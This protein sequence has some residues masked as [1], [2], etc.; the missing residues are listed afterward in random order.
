M[1][2]EEGREESIKTL[3]RRENF[4]DNYWQKRD[5]IIL[6]RLHWRA[7]SFRHLVHLL[8]GQTILEIGC[9]KGLF[10]QQLYDVT[11]NENPITAVTFL[12]NSPALFEN[13]A[14]LE[15]LCLSSLTGQLKGR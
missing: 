1:S 11:R 10:T 8:P 15:F 12:E 7:Q 3:G 5:P 4:R 14:P 2:L 9:G 6:D 13:S